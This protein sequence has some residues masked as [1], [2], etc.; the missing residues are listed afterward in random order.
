M[1]KKFT[2]RKWQTAECHRVKWTVENSARASLLPGKAILLILKPRKR[3]LYSSCDGV[4]LKFKMKNG[5]ASS[6]Q[7][8]I[9]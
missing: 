7:G 2:F 4:P 6:L 3:V 1:F 8:R 5:R 9:I